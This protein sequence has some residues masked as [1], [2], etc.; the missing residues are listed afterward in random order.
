[1]KAR[2]SSLILFVLGCL[3]ALQS[4][5]SFGQVDDWRR[6]KCEHHLVS[7]G[8]GFS[9][10]T[11]AGRSE[12]RA[13]TVAKPLAALSLQ[14]WQEKLQASGRMAYQGNTDWSAGSEF[15]FSNESDWNKT[16]F[17]GRHADL[18]I[19]FGTNS[20]WELAVDKSVDKVVLADW[21]PLPLLAHAYIVAPLMRISR[22]APEFISLLSGEIPSEAIPG[23]PENVS[24]TLEKHSNPA[25]FILEPHQVTQL[26]QYLSSH[27]EIRIDELQF[28]AH[29]FWSRTSE[30]DLQNT[31]LK[32]VRADIF[33]FFQGGYWKRYKDIPAS[34]L[35]RSALHNQA[36]FKKL[37]ELFLKDKV[38]YAM[39]E[40]ADP[41]FYNTLKLSHPKA[42]DWAVSVTNIFEM[43]YNGHTFDTLRD[44]MKNL[45]S[46]IGA[47]E[48]HPL[49]VFRTTNYRVPHRFYRYDLTSE[50]DVPR[51]D[52]DLEYGR[53]DPN[54]DQIDEINV[55]LKFLL[56]PKRIR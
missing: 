28:L 6:S 38:E 27:R 5:T 29:F 46:S 44:F 50:R 43:D 8:Y 47:S 19:A 56:G 49:T 37:R 18:M 36:H 55:L 17:D 34:E 20:F 2:T 35:H 21:S 45:I 7:S 30:K 40:V 22:T 32:G 26:L 54:Q 48:S 10:D 12:L 16:P 53:P 15:L 24:H 39:T 1:M 51:D 52:E 4:P 25:D 11:A 9:F 33:L 42:K 14:K 41:N 31:P 23:T 3:F 13:Q